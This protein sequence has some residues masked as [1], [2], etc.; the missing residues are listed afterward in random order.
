M[1]NRFL[2]DFIR[3][4]NTLIVETIPAASGGAGGPRGRKKKPKHGTPDGKAPFGGDDTES[5]FATLCTEKPPKKTVLEYF[6]DRIT[7]LA[8][9]EL[10]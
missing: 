2:N 3:R 7:E 6:R 8:A 1:E 10:K 5:R 9:E 4:Q